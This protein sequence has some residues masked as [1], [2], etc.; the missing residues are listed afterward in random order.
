MTNCKKL[1]IAV[2]KLLLKLLLCWLIQLGIFP[3]FGATAF[4]VYKSTEERCRTLTTMISTMCIRLYTALMVAPALVHPI[5][6][7]IHGNFDTTT[8]LFPSAM[9]V[10]FSVLTPL[11]F[12]ARVLICGQGALLHMVLLALVI[13]YLLSC[14]S[15]ITACC[16]HFQLIINECDAL[17]KTERCNK[18]EQIKAIFRKMTTGIKMHIK[19]ME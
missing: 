14:F 18:N 4:D 7:M 5:F 9:D 12:Y 8:W 16:K 1:L 17:I 2:N 15:Y 13:P 10:P 11:G 19:I 3:A 6:C